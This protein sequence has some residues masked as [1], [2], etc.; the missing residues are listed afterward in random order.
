MKEQLRQLIGPLPSESGFRQ[1]MRFHQS[2]WRA[3]VL[4]E[5]PGGH[6]VRRGETI[7]NTLASG[8]ESGRNFLTASGREA[9]QQTILERRVG[10]SGLLE[11]ER[12]FNNLLSSQP[13]CFNFFGELK[14]DTDFALQVLRQ[15]WPQITEV[16]R[17]LFEF[18]PA[19]NYT[20]DNS[21]FDVAFEV[22]AGE[23]SGLIGLE[24]KY[25]DNFSPKAY[26]RA[27]YRQ[28]Y[29][30]GRASVFA[31]RYEDLKVG[32]FNQ[33]FR[34]QLIAAALVQHRNYDFT[35]TGLFCHPEDA[36]AQQTGAAFQQM[37]KGGKE[38]FRV[39]TYAELV[40]SIQKLDIAWER[41]QW[42]MLLW[43]RYCGT[44]L[45]EL[46]FS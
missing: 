17:V 41:R 21:A 43:A 25:T 32:R 12:L 22:M 6:P 16:R 39:I 30:A 42:S 24:C 7:G 2:W 34:N 14:L 9:V 38:T 37:L 13:L 5:E 18:A 11:E 23:Q 20:K 35:Y 19:E 4:A 44:Q 45:S 31:A 27:E 10:G 1:R 33:L 29:D 36:S 8:K 15:F 40:E 28:I 3:F 26:D 46:I